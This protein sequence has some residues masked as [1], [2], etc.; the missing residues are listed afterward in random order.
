MV[1][2]DKT[3]GVKFTLKT[4]REMRGLSQIDAAKAIG[5]SVD[6]LSNYERGKS[7]PDI[8]VLRKIEKTYN[9]KYNQLIFL[10]L[11]YGLTVN[12]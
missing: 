12:D 2:L 11:D 8:P 1:A 10:P 9:I 6:T 4:I 5:I 7:Y 3:T